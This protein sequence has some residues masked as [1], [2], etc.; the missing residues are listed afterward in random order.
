MPPAIYLITGEDE[1]LSMRA[2]LYVFVEAVRSIPTATTAIYFLRQT[3][4]SR[5]CLSKARLPKYP[6]SPFW[7]LIADFSIVLQ[8]MI[9]VSVHMSG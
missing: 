1:I 7:Y 2:G 4:H 5:T 3:W 9:F 6:I 8:F